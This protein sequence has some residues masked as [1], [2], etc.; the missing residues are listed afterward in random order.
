MFFISRKAVMS[1]LLLVA[2]SPGA[3]EQAQ[4][5]TV[6]TYSFAGDISLVFDDDNILPADIFVGA[7]YTG[8][9]SYFDSPLDLAP[10]NSLVGSYEFNSSEV[11]SLSAQVGSNTIA[12]SSADDFQDEILIINSREFNMVLGDNLGIE[13]V[14]LPSNPTLSTRSITFNLRSSDPAPSIP[15][16][17]LSDI[18]SLNLADFDNSPFWV[19]ILIDS[20][21]PSKASRFDGRITELELVSA[22][23]IPEIPLP[24]A[25]PLF[26]SALASLGLIGWRRRRR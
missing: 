10:S 5:A 16:D 13:Y 14:P 24:G 11:V 8:Q 17:Q 26:S 25:L 6:Y 19:A 7:S 9:I 3:S 15:S 2:L 1:A 21:D 22:V 18:T 12:R 20:A 23:Q 4:A